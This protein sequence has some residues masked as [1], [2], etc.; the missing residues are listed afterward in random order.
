MQLKDVLKRAGYK[1]PTQQKERTGLEEAKEPLVPQIDPDIYSIAI[2]MDFKLFTQRFYEYIH[3]TK[4][5]SEMHDF[6]QKLMESEF[7]SGKEGKIQLIK[8]LVSGFV[9]LT[10]FDD[11]IVLT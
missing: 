2:N 10:G 11:E 4:H 9:G 8:N 3:I 7:I 1:A 5:F 6:V